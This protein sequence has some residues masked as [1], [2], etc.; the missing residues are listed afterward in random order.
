MRASEE[1]NYREGHKATSTERLSVEK[2][3]RDVINVNVGDSTKCN[4]GKNKE[5]ND[6]S[7]KI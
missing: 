6:Q 5:P 7:I 1:D 3:W 4:E 2:G